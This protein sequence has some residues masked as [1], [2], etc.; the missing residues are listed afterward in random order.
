M[1]DNSKAEEEME[2]LL[3]VIFEKIPAAISKLE[4]LHHLRLENEK[5]K[6][7]LLDEALSQVEASKSKEQKIPADSIKIAIV[8]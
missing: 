5:K 6:G 1:A 7:K 4:E 3:Q 8:I 2:R